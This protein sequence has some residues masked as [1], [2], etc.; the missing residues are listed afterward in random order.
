MSRSEKRAELQRIVNVNNRILK[1]ETN[2]HVRY[3]ALS[4]RNSALSAL[5]L[6][7]NVNRTI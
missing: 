5:H 1:N 2:E 6:M 3:I 7:N 4:K